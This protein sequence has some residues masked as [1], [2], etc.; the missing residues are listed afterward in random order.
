MNSESQTVVVLGASSKRKRYSNM[1]VRR[2]VEKGHRV[3]PVHLTWKQ[4]EGLTVLPSLGDI[5][6]TVNTLSV[7]L[8]PVNSEKLI[9]AIVDLRPERVI[10]NPGAECGKLE[11]SLHD[12]R[13]P[14]LKACTL[15]LLRTGQF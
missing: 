12:N 1:A 4:I 7:Y 13:I 15:V 14:F 10:L 5:K 9:D 8:A 2:L 3:I 11:N 6:E